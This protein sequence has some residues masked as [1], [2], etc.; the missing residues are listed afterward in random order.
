MIKISV[1]KS[2]AIID[3]EDFELVSSIKWYESKVI[4][5]GK[6]Y[7]SYAL[8]KLGTDKKRK[9]V[10]M[11]RLIMGNP[12][13]LVIDHINHNGLD[14]QKSNLRAVTASENQKNLRADSI[15]RQQNLWEYVNKNR[16]IPLSEYEFI[17]TNIHLSAKQLAKKYNVT[18]SLIYFIRNHK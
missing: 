13:G 14:N 12:E 9:T 4:R 3:E 8:G 17:K 15:P 11:H 10:S 5:K 1:G 7:N 16:K 6:Y 2:F 18:D